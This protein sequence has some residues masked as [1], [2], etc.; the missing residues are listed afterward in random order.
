MKVTLKTPQAHAICEHCR[1]KI[2]K[3]CR[4]PFIIFAPGRAKVERF[5]C[6]EC[7]DEIAYL[8]LGVG[9]GERPKSTG[10]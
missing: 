8:I 3:G 2:P 1:G 4:Q 6:W 7:A 10:D 5:V 9:E